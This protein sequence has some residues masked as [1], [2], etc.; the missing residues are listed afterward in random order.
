MDGPPT[1]L[2]FVIEGAVVIFKYKPPTGL[3]PDYCG[4]LPFSF[5]SWG[6]YSV[7][8]V[9]KIGVIFS[10]QIPAF[11]TNFEGSQSKEGEL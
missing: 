4:T 3:S 11:M 1:Q 6:A 7:Y 9:S 5:L 2:D 10:S 8:L